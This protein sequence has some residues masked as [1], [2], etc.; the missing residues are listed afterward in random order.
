MLELL[1]ILIATAIPLDAEDRR[2]Q[3]RLQLVEE[4]L[5]ARR[6]NFLD[7]DLQRAR[8]HHLDQLRVYWQAGRFPKNL[9]GIDVRRP[10]FIDAFGTPCAVAYLMLQSG[11]RAADAARQIA[12]TNNT[13]YADQ[14]DSK[15]FHEWVVT[16][17]LTL[18]EL[19]LI[20][21]S[22]GPNEV[23]LMIQARDEA[24]LKARVEAGKLQ[25][26]RLLIRLAHI[27]SE[28]HSWTALAEWL[29]SRGANPDTKDCPSEVGEGV[30]SCF[31]TTAL[32]VA[33][34][35]AEPSFLRALV[36][37]GGNLNRWKG[38]SKPIYNAVRWATPE[39]VRLLAKL[40][41]KVNG[42]M[43][44]GKSWPPGPKEL[45]PRP[46]SKRSAFETIYG[47][48]ALEYAL[49]WGDHEMVRTL[50][51]LGARRVR[52]KAPLPPVSPV[53][54]EDI[55]RSVKVPGVIDVYFVKGSRANAKA[56]LRKYGLKISQELHAEWITKRQREHPTF[57]VYEVRV[58]P[59][60]EAHTACRLHVDRRVY[61][62]TGVRKSALK[63]RRRSSAAR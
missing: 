56:V 9:D 4:L 34:M 33:A 61:R 15:P 2:I 28:K 5:R 40:G 13:I 59:G 27:S 29:L 49:R 41:A 48:G 18:E 44:R 6:V 16:S 45:H 20:Q 26:T 31:P 52:R 50:R 47:E 30:G 60:K 14:I 22:Y 3:A 39:R 42:R 35:S 17:G 37:G 25:P 43:Y 7:A 11:G 53:C 1:A 24:A 46:T 10:F 51:K 55:E 36:R 8:T 23:G 32:G 62:A 54:L 63:S 58:E 12:R 57:R 19:A 21:P 38:D